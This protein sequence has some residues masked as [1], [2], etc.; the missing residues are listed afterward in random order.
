MKTALFLMMGLIKV[1]HAALPGAAQALD[2][3]GCPGAITLEQSSNIAEPR[4]LGSGVATGQV[5]LEAMAAGWAL[6]CPA[7]AGARGQSNVN[8]TGI[9]LNRTINVAVGHGAVAVQN[10]G[11]KTTISTGGETATVKL[12]VPAGVRIVARSWSGSLQAAPGVWMVDAEL[13]SG[14]MHFSRLHDSAVVVDSG[15][16]SALEA[17]GRLTAHLRGAGSIEVAN[18]R[19]AALDLQLTGAGSMA[20]R[21]RA[22]S[23]RVQATGAGHIEIEHV[24]SEP[25]IQ[26]RGLAT[27]DI[28]R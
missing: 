18:M 20:F 22:T 13:A 28:G 9:T 5:R 27:V 4:L 23:A 7:A 8:V 2:I 21:G 1:A 26:L 14:Q 12:Q 17:T 15:S 6:R 24:T 10:I 19:D 11:G 3:S 25:S 16:L